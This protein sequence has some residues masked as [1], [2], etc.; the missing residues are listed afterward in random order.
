MHWAFP[1]S[2]WY[3][4]GSHD[5]QVLLLSE[6]LMNVPTA[7]CLH[8]LPLFSFWYEPGLQE[9]QKAELCVFLVE[10][11]DGHLSHVSVGSGRKM[12]KKSGEMKRL[13]NH[14]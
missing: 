4:P 14:D 5:V 12:V 3:F 9:E 1:F 10:N 6:I 13:E 7:H 8:S 2:S 11:P